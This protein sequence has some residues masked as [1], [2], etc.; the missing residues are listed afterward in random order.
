MI[1]TF[2]KGFYTGL[3]SA[4]GYSLLFYFDA[5]MLVWIPIWM[6]ASLLLNILVRSTVKKH[7][8]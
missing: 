7:N 2:S 1:D 8:D 6:L 5:N 3:L 4:F